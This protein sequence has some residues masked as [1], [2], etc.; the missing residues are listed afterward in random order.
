MPASSETLNEPDASKYVDN[1]DIN[2][3]I[4]RDTEATNILH[5]SA[6]LVGRGLWYKTSAE[7]LLKL[8]TVNRWDLVIIA[9]RFLV[10]GYICCRGFHYGT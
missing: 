8:R 1:S 7:N 2:W 10:G 3:D 9:T 4:T 6:A 5:L